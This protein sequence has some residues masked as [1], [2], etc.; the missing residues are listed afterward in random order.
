MF[1][2]FDVRHV[3]LPFPIPGVRDRPREGRSG[4]RGPARRPTRKFSSSLL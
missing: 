3:S 1:L 2:R 4:G